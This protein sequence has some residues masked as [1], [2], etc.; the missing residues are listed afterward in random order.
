[1]MIIKFFEMIGKF[2]WKL[3]GEAS[4]NPEPQPRMVT[5]RRQSEPMFA[6]IKKS[7]TVIQTP[8]VVRCT[9]VGKHRVAIA[10]NGHTWDAKVIG[11]V[12]IGGMNRIR[13]FG[14]VGRGEPVVTCRLETDV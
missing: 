8:A 4:D 3:V 13:T 9:V 11:G 6:K 10:E 1:M 2:F 5:E 12:K 14:H 7:V